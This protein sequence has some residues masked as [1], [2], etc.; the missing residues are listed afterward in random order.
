MYLILFNR[1]S[2]EV[3]HK[4]IKAKG[5]KRKGMKGKKTKGEKQKIWKLRKGGETGREWYRREKTLKH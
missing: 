2:G 4:G 1:S 5:M 3:H